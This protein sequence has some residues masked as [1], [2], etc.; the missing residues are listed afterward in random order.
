MSRRKPIMHVYAGTARRQV[1]GSIWSSVRRGAV[2]LI[3][4]L[5]NK[6]RP[7]AV[8]AGKAL[9]ARTAKSAINVG[10][11]MAS[12]AIVGRLNRH[13]AKDIFKDEFN[14]IRHDANEQVHDYKRRL[15]SQLQE[16]SG[17][18]RRRMT[19]SKSAKRRT[20]R[21]APKRRYSRKKKRPA[22]KTVRKGRVQ[23]KRKVQRR[24]KRRVVNTDIFN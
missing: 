15:E 13:K 21:K 5:L 7:H 11:D 10:A 23:K 1:G 2:P 6:L 3:L 8:N 19:R 18:K 24:R 22:K 4:T 14:Q 12:N 17:A 16:G 9:A 20:K